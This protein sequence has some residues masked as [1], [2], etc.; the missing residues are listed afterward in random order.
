[1][2]AARRSIVSSDRQRLLVERARGLR[3]FSTA[4]ERKL[5]QALSGEQCG[6]SFRRQVPLLGRFIAD[7]FAPSVGLV[8]EVDGSVHERTRRADAR[9]DEV[10]RRV[11]YHVLRVDAEVVLGDLELAAAIV[12]AAVEQLR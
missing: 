10:L 2:R 12:R 3:Q 6:V 9:R 11:G 7:F 1:M 8:V 4:S 5:W